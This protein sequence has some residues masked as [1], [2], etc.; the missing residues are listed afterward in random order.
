M[1]ISEFEEKRYEREME[2]FLLRHRPPVHIRDDMDIG[3]RLE[4]QS[5]EIFEIRPHWQNRSEKIETP[6]AKATYVKSQKEW[7]IYWHKSDMK[8]HRYEPTPEV[9]AFE[10]FLSV[11]G[12]DSHSC[13]WG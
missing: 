6:V 11:V 4:R 10:E 1:A 2:R 8:W 13:F 12:E 5:V 7:R 3:Y 9:K